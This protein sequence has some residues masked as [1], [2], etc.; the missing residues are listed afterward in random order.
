MA[1]QIKDEFPSFSCSQ[2]RTLRLCVDSGMRVKVMCSASGMWT[3]RLCPSPFLQL[4]MWICFSILDHRVKSFNLGEAVH[5]ETWIHDVMEPLN[6]S[7]TSRPQKAFTITDRHFSLVSATVS[8]GLCYHWSL[9]SRKLLLRLS[10]VMSFG[11]FHPVVLPLGMYMFLSSLPKDSPSS[12]SQQPQ[13]PSHHYL[14]SPSFS[15]VTLGHISLLWKHSACLHVP[16]ASHHINASQAGRIPG[17]CHLPHFRFSTLV[18]QPAFINCQW[19][20]MYPESYH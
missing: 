1:T 13:S 17:D 16:Y 12:I 14:F 4:L 8:F 9:T 19:I 7:W 2:K 20:N 6:Q 3:E 10:W 5:Q 11:S 15:A 18:S